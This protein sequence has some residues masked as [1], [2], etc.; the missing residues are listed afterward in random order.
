M[1]Y[2]AVF[3]YSLQ[4][5]KECRQLA[6]GENL[7]WISPGTQQEI[8][9]QRRTGRT[10]QEAALEEMQMMVYCFYAYSVRVAQ[11]SRQAK[12]KQQGQWKEIQEFNW[13]REITAMSRGEFIRGEIMCLLWCEL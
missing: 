9:R 12:L 10:Y 13:Q 3:T 2:Q 5:E 7:K 8:E 6:F 4:K 1:G 11:E